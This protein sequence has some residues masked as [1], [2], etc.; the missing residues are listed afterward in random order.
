MLD[1]TEDVIDS[2]DVIQRLEELKIEWAVTTGEDADD[3]SLSEDDWSVGLGWDGAVEIVALLEL[4]DQG[5][6]LA[7]WEYGE[8]LIRDSYFEEYAQ[9][10]A[11]D[12][13]AI[14]SDASLGWPLGYIDW[15]RAAEALQMDYTP[16]E[17]DGVT[18]WARA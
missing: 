17:F 10:L 6:S 7:D 12:I 16:I 5:A 15:E 8:T 9:Q 2:R 4:A 18:Y 3:F 1:N 14:D 13:G 11:E